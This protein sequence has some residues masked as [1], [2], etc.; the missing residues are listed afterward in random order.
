M[1]KIFKS[2]SDII[3]V[4]KKHNKDQLGAGSFAQV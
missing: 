1:G 3:L 4:K 2:I